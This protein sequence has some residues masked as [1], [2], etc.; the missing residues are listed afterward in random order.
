ML[1][2]TKI[3]QAKPAG[4]PYKLPDGGGL[5]L[6][7]TPAGSKLWRYRYEFAEREKTLSIGTY[8]D[9]SLAEAR[10]R[11]DEARGLVTKG[12]DPGIKKKVDR[13]T[14]MIAAADTFEA[15]AR[16]WHALHQ[17]KWATRHAAVFR[18]AARIA[19]CRLSAIVAFR[20]RR[21]A[22]VC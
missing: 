3:R 13:A 5:H 6:Y 20:R 15:L 2:D 9:V 18:R 12:M 1:T 17:A 8:P 4:K 11:R 7:V 21:I 22:F 19:S 14:A 10:G 16:E